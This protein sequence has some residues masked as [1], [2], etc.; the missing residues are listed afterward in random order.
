MKG[1][2][3]AASFFFLYYYFFIFFNFSSLF[4]LLLLISAPLPIVNGTDL[5]EK[6]DNTSACYVLFLCIYFQAMDSKSGLKKKKKDSQD[7]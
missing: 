5:C 1:G 3:A 2:A 7:N 6:Q 4:H